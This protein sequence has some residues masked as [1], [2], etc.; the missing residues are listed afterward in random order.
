[1]GYIGGAIFY[2]PWG[3]LGPFGLEVVILLVIVDYITYNTWK[4]SLKSSLNISN[5][6]VNLIL[7]FILS[8][9][10]GFQ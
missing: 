7:R 1:M 4:T 10:G 6:H 8:C 2:Y 3:G 5:S 9:Q